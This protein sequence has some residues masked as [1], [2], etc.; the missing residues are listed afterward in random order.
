VYSLHCPLSSALCVACVS[1]RPIIWQSS[2][3]LSVQRFLGRPRCLFSMTTT[4][5]GSVWPLGR[6]HSNYMAKVSKMAVSD[7]VHNVMLD[8][9]LIL[10]VCI[11]DVRGS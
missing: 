8:V 7:P 2:E 3:M 6:L 4:I 10:D 1:E 11:S 9:E 5:Q